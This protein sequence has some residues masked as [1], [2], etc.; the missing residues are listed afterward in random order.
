[1]IYNPWVII[2]TPVHGSLVFIINPLTTIGRVFP[3]SVMQ[4]V[5]QAIRM[6]SLKG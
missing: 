5:E 6:Q 3:N 1:M 4:F 2:I